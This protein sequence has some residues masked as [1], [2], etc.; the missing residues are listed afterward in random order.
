MTYYYPELSEDA[1]QRKRLERRITGLQRELARLTAQHAGLV[2]SVREYAEL[3]ADIDL[4][5]LVD[6][7]ENAPEGEKE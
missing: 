3:G 6:T 5:V 1:Q 7:C 2:A 4:L